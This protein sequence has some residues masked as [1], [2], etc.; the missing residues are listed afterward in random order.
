M[1]PNGRMFP[2]TA[3]LVTLCM[4]VCDSLHS[5]ACENVCDMPLRLAC[6]QLYAVHK[7]NVPA[8]TVRGAEKAARWCV[9]ASCILGPREASGNEVAAAEHR[10]VQ[11]E[12]AAAA[13][14][15]CSKIG[16][17]VTGNA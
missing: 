10:T 13:S 15:P 16:Q 5:S 4:P 9:A 1:G 6:Q 12:A 17:A 14:R 7:L 3:M 11:Q 2:C 8:L